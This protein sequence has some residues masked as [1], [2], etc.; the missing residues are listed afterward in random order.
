MLGLVS[1]LPVQ[2]GV[3]C[4]DAVIFNRSVK[5]CSKTASSNCQIVDHFGI[6]APSTA[7]RQREYTTTKVLQSVAHDANKVRRK[8]GAQREVES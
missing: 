2:L 4:F 5:I 8:G 1:V 7:P 3:I 6:T